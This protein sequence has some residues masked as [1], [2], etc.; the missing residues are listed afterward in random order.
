M[1]GVAGGRG[2]AAWS[3]EGDVLALTLPATLAGSLCQNV[4]GGLSVRVALVKHSLLSAR[5][6]G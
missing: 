6:L 4:P 1:M 3:M 5:A 2:W